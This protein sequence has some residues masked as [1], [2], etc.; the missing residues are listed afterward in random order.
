M[1]RAIKN[2]F[3]APLLHHQPAVHHHHAAADLRHH[4]EIVRDQ[5]NR[6]LG[7][8]LQAFQQ[9]QDLRLNGNVQ[10]GGRLIGNKQLR[11]AGERNGDHHPL[12]H[13]A[14][15]LVGILVVS[16]FRLGN[17]HLFQ[18]GDRRRFGR[19]FG[20]PFIAHQDLC[21]LFT[22]GQH[23]VQGGHRILKNHR[24]LVAANGAHLRRGFLRQIVILEANAAAGYP[25]VAPQKLNDRLT[26]DAFPAARL[27]DD[28]D[29]LPRLHLKAHAAHRVNL[30]LA[31]A[32]GGLQVLKR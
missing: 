29:K 1:R 4:A 8:L 28:A 12:A 30:A 23:R 19:S 6:G 2:V 26:G 14:A 20:E 16:A 3:H 10:R 17:P 7:L 18:H 11:V 13:P 15:E 31:G 9:S 5:Q 25:S 27:A 32:E 21:H 22:D 24:D